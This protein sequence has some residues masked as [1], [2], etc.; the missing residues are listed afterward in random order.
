MS[1]RLNTIRGWGAALA[2]A[3]S[4]TTFATPLRAQP[5]DVLDRDSDN[6][7]SRAEASYDRTLSKIFAA[8]DLDG[9]GFMDRDEYARATYSTF[10]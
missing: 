7:L 5:F 2:L 3:V 6:R 10:I 4:V 9:D 1:T 8:S